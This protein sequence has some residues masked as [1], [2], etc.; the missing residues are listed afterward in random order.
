MNKVNIA[1]E[2]LLKT[3]ITELKFNY[4][5][6]MVRFNLL[7]DNNLPLHAINRQISERLIDARRLLP[8]KNRPINSERIH[9]PC[10]YISMAAH[11]LLLA[12][13]SLRLHPRTQYC[14]SI[15]I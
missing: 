5:S 14:D 2:F 3:S 13:D 1:T 4:L 7:I 6:V 9:F 12:G 11:E 8:G 15:I 10:A